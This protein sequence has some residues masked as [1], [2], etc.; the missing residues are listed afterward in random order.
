MKSSSIAVCGTGLV[1][2]AAALGLARAGCKP[3]L[4]GPRQPPAPA[5]CDV[6]HPR[7][8]AVSP[9]AQGFLQ[10]LGVWG[11]L[12]AKRITAVE[13]MQ[14]HGD[15]GG[16]V[17]LRAWQRMQPALA[18]IVESGELERGLYQ[19]LQIFG[20]DWLEDRFERLTP[21]GLATA[22]GRELAAQLVIGADG[23]HSAVRQAAGIAFTERDYHQV[24]LVAH[25]TAQVPHDGIARQWFVDGEVVALLPMPDT[26]Q[27]PQVSL[28]WSMERTRAQAVLAMASEA[29]AEYVQALL[30]A[31]TGG[32]LGT[33]AVRADVLGFPL[34]LAYSDMIA[35]G[36]ALVGDAAHRVHPLAGQ[37]LNLGL[38]DVEHLLRVLVEKPALVSPGDETVLRRYRRARAEPVWAMRMA[39]DGLHRLFAADLPPL[40]LGR[41]LGM[42]L[43]DRL[44]WVKQRL[45]AAASNN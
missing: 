36:V 5:E 8:Y 24:G 44:P 42:K 9:P 43:V 41:N 4:L 17:D 21:E 25:L 15:A 34:T 19:A 23:M 22:S 32:C 6:Y 38:G 35:P 26:A 2:L 18:W 14:V 10:E 1:G 37:G 29:R 40:V 16:S 12:D 31:V 3:C 28:V 7:V 39:T 33:L 20:V 45:I 13:G 11:L 27:G 30:A